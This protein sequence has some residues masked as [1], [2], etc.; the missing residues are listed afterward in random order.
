LIITGFTCSS[1]EINWVRKL[2]NKKS[3][4]WEPRFL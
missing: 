1:V 3:R 2:V 4:S